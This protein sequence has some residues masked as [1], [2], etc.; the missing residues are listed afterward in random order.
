MEGS[1]K[2][3]EQAIADSR[4]GVVL[5]LGELG[6]GLTTAHREN[7]SLLRN[8]HRYSLGLGLIVWYYL[9]TGLSWLRIGACDGH[10]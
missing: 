3:I 7:V 2:Y 5:Q 6:E 8:I 4:Q 1:C 9:W 10:L